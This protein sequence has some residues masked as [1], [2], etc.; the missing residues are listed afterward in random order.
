MCQVYGCACM[1]LL[2]ADTVLAQALAHSTGRLVAA[3]LT[4]I[5]DATIGTIISWLAL[6]E[7]LPSAQSLSSLGVLAAQVFIRLG[8]G[9]LASASSVWRSRDSSPVL[10]ACP[11]QVGQGSHQP[12]CG[13]QSCVRGPNHD[14]AGA[15]WHAPHAA[16]GALRGLGTARRAQMTFYLAS[17]NGTARHSQ[18]RRA[19][20][21][22]HPSHAAISLVRWLGTVRHPQLMHCITQ[23]S[24]F[25]RQGGCTGSIMTPSAQLDRPGGMQRV[26]ISKRMI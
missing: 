22:R 1:Q 13:W 17:G 4:G 2:S 20:A 15:G 19:G 18:S 25:R 12:G 21:C 5:E 6:R 24:T 26:Y 3:I 7:K 23:K 9:V 10:L 8:F 11:S 14:A 16:L